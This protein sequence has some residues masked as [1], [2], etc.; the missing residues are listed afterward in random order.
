M[1]GRGGGSLCKSILSDEISLGSVEVPLFRFC[2]LEG[3]Q[4][5]QVVFLCVR[6]LDRC[7]VGATFGWWAVGAA[8]AGSSGF[9]FRGL[10]RGRAAIGG[11]G[12]VCIAFFG[13]EGRS[14][15]SCAE[16]PWEVEGALVVGRESGGVSGAAVVF[17]AGNSGVMFAVAGVCSMWAGLRY[18]RATF[19]LIPSFMISK[20]DSPR[21]ITSCGP[22]YGGTRQ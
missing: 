21:E 14:L 5:V 1:V 17:P 7:G 19:F 13:V 10:P 9:C 12:P 20:N 16:G 6:W 22:V 18:W 4:H 15:C 8:L 2:E 11:A 3:S